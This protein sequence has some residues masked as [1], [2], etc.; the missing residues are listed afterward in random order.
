MDKSSEASKP[1]QPSIQSPVIQQPST[2]SLPLRPLQTKPPAADPV[3]EDTKSHETSASQQGRKKLVP[4]SRVEKRSSLAQSVE[5]SM[6]EFRHP[7][8]L[9]PT[10]LAVLLRPNRRSSTRVDLR[11]NAHVRYNDVVIEKEVPSP[12][13]NPQYSTSPESP[14]AKFV[15]NSKRKAQSLEEK[16]AEIM[17]SSP[18]NHPINRILDAHFAKADRRYE[19]EG[20]GLHGTFESPNSKKRRVESASDIIKNICSMKKQKK[21]EGAKDKVQSKSVVTASR[22]RTT[23]ASFQDGLR[24][25]FKEA[26]INTPRRSKARIAYWRNL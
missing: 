8:E 25:L 24:E 19:E 15:K 12:G 16:C 18:S 4:K 2:I 3:R 14:Y 17:V 20:I 23:S 11:D 5:D 6:G 22:Q 1:K 7:K 21:D 13:S 10:S 26:T 9:S